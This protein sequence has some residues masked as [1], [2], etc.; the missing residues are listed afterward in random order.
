MLTETRYYVTHPERETSEIVL[1]HAYTHI[2]DANRE[3]QR[4]INNPDVHADIDPEGYRVEPIQFNYEPAT[5]RYLNAVKEQIQ[6]N[7]LANIIAFVGICLNALLGV[8]AAISFFLGIH[9]W[10][11]I[12]TVINFITFVFGT[13]WILGIYGSAF[14]IMETKEENITRLNNF[15]ASS[16]VKEN[17][18][19][20]H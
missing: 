17:T 18:H 9:N 14:T 13:S 6:I 11:E 15:S 5:R 2:T 3:A 8:I 16:L 12:A 19:A 20:H 4:R 10:A 7:F 1:R